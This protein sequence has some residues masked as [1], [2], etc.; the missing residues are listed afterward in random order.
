M[1]DTVD[2]SHVIL[3]TAPVEADW[4]ARLHSL[5][6]G[7][8]IEHWSAR[9]ARAIPEDLWRDVEI[10]FTSFA[11]RLPPPEQA[12]MLRWVQLYSAG[13]DSILDQPLF[14]TDVVFTTASGV[15]AINMA[16]YIFTVVL[17]W[18]HRLPQI[19][20]WQQHGQWPSS[21]ERSSLLVPEELRGKTIGIVGYGSIGRHIARLADA[22]GMLVLAMQRSADHRDRGFQFPGVGDPEGTLPGRY[23]TPDQLQSMLSESDVVIIA[24]PLTSKT[25]GLF[26]RAAFE[27]MKPTAFLVNISRGDVCNEVALVRALEEKQIA[28]AALDVFHQEP[29]PPGHPLWSLPNAFISPHISGLTPHY[30]GRVAAIFEENLRR[31][32]A[33]ESLYN[34]VDKTQG[35]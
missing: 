13:P 19:F 31:Y 9:S 4:L 17:A 29:L 10:L 23:Y 8:Q 12:P 11:T 27:A 20:E 18:F 7:L 34:V 5:S 24:V 32:L 2:K 15:H 6:P 1:A 33:G 25:R 35:Y 14:Q 26:D 21:S 22:F 3:I 16:E 28:G 30:N